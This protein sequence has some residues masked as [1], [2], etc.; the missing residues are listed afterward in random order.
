MSLLTP[1]LALI[2]NRLR[3]RLLRITAL[4]ALA[5]SCFS[6]GV[7]ANN[8]PRLVTSSTFGISTR[9]SSRSLNNMSSLSS[10]KDGIIKEQVQ[11]LSTSVGGKTMSSKLEA[12]RTRMRDLHL[13]CYIIPTDD[14]HLSGELTL[15]RYFKIVFSEFS[16]FMI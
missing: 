3:H 15:L 5:E 4:F 7:Y 10:C 13:D 8:H 11:D 12:L 14:P 16:P 2:H 1:K 6:F 9:T